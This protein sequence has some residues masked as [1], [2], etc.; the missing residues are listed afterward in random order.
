[1]SNVITIE[2]LRDIARYAYDT[3]VSGSDTEARWLKNRQKATELYC[4][5]LRVE[6]ELAAKRLKRRR[7]VK[8]TGTDGAQ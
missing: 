2:K 8:A 6:N 4:N 7:Q 1:M 3:A 5:S